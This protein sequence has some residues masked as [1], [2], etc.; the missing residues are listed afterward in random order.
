M[1]GCGKAGSCNRVIYF[2]RF[3]KFGCQRP[4]VAIGGIAL[5]EVPLH[6]FTLDVAIP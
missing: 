2:Q 3:L 6:G 5:G 4:G 1:A